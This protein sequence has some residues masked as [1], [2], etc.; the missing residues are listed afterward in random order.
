MKTCKLIR[1]VLAV[2]VCCGM[3]LSLVPTLGVSADTV[4]TVEAETACT[5]ITAG[6][7]VVGQFEKARS[8]T[9]WSG[10]KFSFVNVTST[11]AIPPEVTA[12]FTLTVPSAGRYAIAM[13]HKD[14]GDRGIWNVALDDTAVG[15]VDL[16]NTTAGFVTHTLGEVDITD[17]EVT[18]TL[19]C[20]GAN[21][22]SSKKYGL[23][24]DY[25]TLT[26][27]GDVA[28]V[29]TVT[30]ADDGYNE[31]SGSWEA[32]TADTT[33]ITRD[34]TASASWSAY[35][36]TSDIADANY[37]ISVFVP[38]EGLGNATYTI[39]TLSG[40]WKITLDQSTATDNWVKLATVGAV[41]DTAITVTLS[42]VAGKVA[43]DSLQIMATADPADEQY[44]PDDVVE[45][46][47][48]Y[49]RVNQ[50]GYDA[51]KSKRATVVNV[52]DNTDFTIKD[53]TTNATLFTGKVM[54]QVADF[55][56]FV[57]ENRVTC[58]LECE[59]VQSYRFMVGKYVMQQASVYNAL[60]FMEQSRADTFEMGAK[61]YAW[62]DS[63]QFSFEMSSL[64]QQYMANPSLYDQMDYDVY[65]A[66]ECEY[67]ELQV[68]DEPNIV[69]LM[70]FAALR[71]FDLA[72]TDG[73]KL[74]MLI[75]E[76][77][78]WFLYAYPFIEQYV[79]E[80]MYL[81]IR[82]LAIETWGETGC[83]LQYHQVDG[84]NYWNVADA[85][86]SKENHNLFALQNVVGGIKGQLPP[87]HA[88]A[89]NLMMYEVLTRDGIAGADAYLQAAI[90]NCEWVINEIDITDPA[91]AKGQRMSEHIVM[92]NLAFFLEEYPD[93]APA[94]L[95]QAITDWA[96][97]M[98]AR[99]ENK[100]DMRMASS[101]GAG[102]D[103]DA[104]TGAAY[105]SK[106]GQ[107]PN[108][109]M[110]EPGNMAGL[111][112]ALEAAA[113][114]LDDE[115]I[116]AR[117]KA[118]GI[119]AID[120]MFGR[121]PLDRS[122]FNNTDYMTEFA[123]ADKGWFNKHGHG[124]GVLGEVPGRIDGAPKEDAYAGSS[125]CNVNAGAG[126]TE[127]WVAYNTAWN[128]SLAYSAAAD[129]DLSVE[130]DTVKVGETVTLTLKAPLNMDPTKVESATVQVKNLTTG[131]T[132]TLTLTECSADD[133]AFAAEVGVENA[134]DVLE[135]SYGYG[136]FEN[137]VTLTGAA[138]DPVVPEEPVVPGQTVYTFDNAE[139]INDWTVYSNTIT[140]ENGQ[141]KA[142]NTGGTA[143]GV[144]TDVTLADGTVSA[145]V[146]VDTTRGAGLVFR[147]QDKSNFLHFR[148][149]GGEA[150]LYQF[151]SSGNSKL[152]SAAY[153]WSINTT[154][155]L[156]V[157][158]EGSYIA[159][160]VD[161]NE[162]LSY[163]LTN[164]TFAVSGGIGVRS[165]QATLLMDT[166][167]VTEKKVI[168]PTQTVK[169]EAETVGHY[170]GD[171]DIKGYS[172]FAREGDGWSEGKFVFF[173]Q[174]KGT[175]EAIP[176]WG[177]SF[178]LTVDKAGIYDLSIVYKTGDSRGVWDVY[179]DGVFLE[180]L[181]M[182]AATAEMITHTFE[183]VSFA[184][185]TATLD[186]VCAGMNEKSG[187]V[188][189][190]M[191]VDYFEILSYEDKP[192][193]NVWAHETVGQITV[194]GD[195]YVQI[196]EATYGQETSLTAATLVRGDNAVFAGWLVNGL[197]YQPNEEQALSLLA[198]GVERVTAYFVRVDEAVVLYYG[199]SNHVV[200]ADIVKEGATPVLPAVPAVHGHRPGAWDTDEVGLQIAVSENLGD[201][202]TVTASYEVDTTADTF[203]VTLLNGT[204][205]GS[206]TGLSFDSRITV[207]A[208]ETLSGVDFSHWEVD[209]MPVA[210]GTLSYT[211]Y[212]GGNHTVKAVYA[213]AAEEK[214][215][216]GIQQ[217]YAVPQGD[218]YKVMMVA[219]T[220]LPEGYTLLD[221][222]MYFAREATA[223]ADPASVTD[224]RV[225]K[226]VSSM[227]KPNR[228]YLTYLIG[229]K[230]G[231]TRCGRAYLTVRNDATGEITVCY[232]Q[233][234]TVTTGV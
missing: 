224:G 83:T 123:G 60:A 194:E 15:Q 98:I 17:G 151:S 41:E 109:T 14:G 4:I 184:D 187:N 8:G 43:A 2:L 138:A 207:T 190:G 129:V 13:V 42:E 70:E 95:K 79:P 145:T 191:A 144:L 63:H 220:Y 56:G 180:R 225:V 19:T 233:I 37:A 168:K 229:T 205:D 221:Y 91:Y 22:A 11:T 169:I 135:I 130:A 18:V 40:T 149:S 90:D 188:K 72:K 215:A 147:A 85:A 171:A 31:L 160:Y 164:E 214:P 134:D 192:K 140:V 100:W 28:G 132:S 76:Q 6:S 126:Y 212:V 26:P 92:E 9:G 141:L 143:L 178:E 5:A 137:A 200:A 48:V 227:R 206:T 102:D 21:A 183:N 36:P 231:A 47:T 46:D 94:G 185:T 158:M 30:P 203:D 67:E 111:Q 120:D 162:V 174:E 195:G 84:T 150:Q 155:T 33:R 93:K 121:N 1:R 157:E 24:L 217:A 113:R 204:T 71:Y 82:D 176:H 35:P 209:G 57:P 179:L 163:T 124:N 62:R 73:V 136:Q 175:A 198:S 7:G 64:V 115:A 53:A 74:H 51:D 167:T 78:A 226:V 52:A 38:A 148:F 222:G 173:N 97:V 189:Y 156:S 228:Q 172:N 108:C 117:L 219:N 65:L 88:I 201:I 122:Y 186:L 54:G 66:A 128:A 3:L 105:A 112:A 10:G 44:D 32:G 58:Y 68:Q 55:T 196:G 170:L 199:K 20:A 230:V 103:F 86:N 197:F 142:S 146:S 104:W 61:G 80:E 181:D 99:A 45:D 81:K 101:T 177:A 152:A 234:E 118:L 114:V 213:A 154:Y 69:W 29:T 218:S 165:Y 16:Y 50:I 87:G 106:S 133:Y 210:Y 208:E 166:L 182:Y 119:A 125:Q 159:C 27:L 49:V 211:F 116:V 107:Y 127:A 25:F 232:S 202:V 39:Q 110:N 139:D 223:L 96:E 89:P 23:A 77:L 193:E 59:G 161:G 75:K 216:V 131:A 153:A 34:A 12:T